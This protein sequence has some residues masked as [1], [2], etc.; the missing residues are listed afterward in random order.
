[1]SDTQPPFY[2]PAPPPSGDDWPWPWM[3]GVL[4]V[5]GLIA[6]AITLRSC[7]VAGL[8]VSIGAAG[9]AL[10]AVLPGLVGD[11]AAF[12]GKAFVFIAIYG[13]VAPL[14]SAVTGAAADAIVGDR[15]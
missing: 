12:C 8:R 2:D 10:G 9:L 3:L 11:V 7:V 13:L 4:A 5:A 14:E 6:S 15:R 1:M